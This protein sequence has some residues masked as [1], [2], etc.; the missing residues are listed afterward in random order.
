MD[1]RKFVREVL[2][3]F[4]VY[5]L[6]AEVGVARAATRSG[7][8]TDGWITRQHEI[9]VALARGEIAPGQWRAEVES[10]AGSVD[11]PQLMADLAR[12]DTRFI[13]RA[14]PS[15]PIKRTIRFRD[16]TGARRRLRYGVAL[17]TF[18][19][20]NVV[21]PHAHRNMVSAHLVVEGAFRVRT[22]GPRARRRRRDRHPPVG[23]RDH[24]RRRRLDHRHPARQHPLVRAAHGPRGHAGRHRLRPGPDPTP[25]CDRGRRPGPRRPTARRD[26]PRP[27][28][29]FRGGE[30]D[31]HTG[32][33]T[34]TPKNGVC[35]GPVQ[36]A[37]LSVEFSGKSCIEAGSRT[38]FV[39]FER[40]RN[41]FRYKCLRNGRGLF[42]RGSKGNR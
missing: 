27:D 21:T 20:R 3:G 35:S 23:G 38:I 25:V 30:P 34:R 17:F 13:G 37:W 7:R 10:L 28:P 40:R 24:P 5:A 26:D 29:R 8:G 18:D 15:Y 41:R 36:A 39:V 33:L 11:V 4:P 1:R 6:L 2:A 12:A 14:L 22:F 31:L 19:R 32:R 9:A 16:A 42:C